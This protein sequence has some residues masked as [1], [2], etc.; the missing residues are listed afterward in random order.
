[1][2]GDVVVNSDRRLKQ[3]IAPIDN[4]LALLEK[5]EGRTYHWKPGL[6]RDDRRHY[7]LIAQ[8]VEAAV[9]ELVSTNPVDG[10]KSVN[11]QGFI[12]ILINGVEEL[13]EQTDKTQAGMDDLRTQ[14]EK[15]KALLETLTASNSQ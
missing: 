7:G 2:S 8:E 15:N 3:D 13:K 9:P 11:Y 14:F 4:A 6:G 5:V 1:M 12:P 10:I